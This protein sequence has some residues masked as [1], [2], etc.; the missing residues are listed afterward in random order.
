MKAIMNE[1]NKFYD[2]IINYT[3]EEQIEKLI[4][5]AQKQ[6]LDW[7]NPKT[8]RK[9]IE[10]SSDSIISPRPRIIEAQN[11]TKMFILEGG[12]PKGLV[13]VNYFMGI[14][15]AFDSSMRRNKVYQLPNWNRQTEYT[16]KVCCNI[17]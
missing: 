7:Y 13:F 10:V 1:Q 4:E 3:R 8:S 12:E 5:K 15:I 17:N 16:E 2:S 14:V 9:W 6:V 11:I